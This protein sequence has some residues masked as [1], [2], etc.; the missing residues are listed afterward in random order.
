MNI[1]NVLVRQDGGCVLGLLLQLVLDRRGVSVERGVVGRWQLEYWSDER[2]GQTRFGVYFEID[3]R[4]TLSDEYVWERNNI[5]I[6][7]IDIILLNFKHYY[8]LFRYLYYIRIFISVLRKQR[9]G[10]R[11]PLTKLWV[12]T[13]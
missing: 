4:R 2:L 9:V 10:I 7:Y 6:V 13:L 3:G 1:V 5:N 8:Y 11:S 12:N